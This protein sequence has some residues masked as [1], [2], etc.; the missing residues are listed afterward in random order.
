MTLDRPISLP[1]VEEID[2]PAG[3]RILVPLIEKSP[4]AIVTFDPEGVVTMMDVTE[5]KSAGDVE[6]VRQV[7]RKVREALD[8]A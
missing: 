7:A 5:H 4:L 1:D 3:S 8:S 2:R 6:V